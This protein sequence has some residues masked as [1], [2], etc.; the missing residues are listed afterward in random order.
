CGELVGCGFRRHHPSGDPQT[1][2]G[3]VHSRD[4]RPRMTG[5]TRDAKLAS[6]QGVEGVVHRCGQT[7]G[8][9]RVVVI[10]PIC[11]V[12]SPR[13]PCRPT[14]PSGFPVGPTPSSPCGCSRDGF[15]GC[16]LKGSRTSI[17]RGT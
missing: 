7:Y 5:A 9:V 12:S 10:I 1:E 4:W 11:I 3:L 17:V 2:T 8:I 16:T 14:G 13:G 15:G 6:P